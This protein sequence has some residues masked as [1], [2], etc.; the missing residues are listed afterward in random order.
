MNQVLY[1]YG[2]RVARSVPGRLFAFVWILMSVVLMALLTA[3]LSAA[4]TSTT[5]MKDDM[6]GSKV[7]AMLQNDFCFLVRWQRG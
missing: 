5:V 1:R 7:S 4:L 6:G 2:D 3:T